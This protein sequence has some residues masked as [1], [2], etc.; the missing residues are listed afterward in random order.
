MITKNQVQWRIAISV[1]DSIGLQARYLTT[2]KEFDTNHELVSIPRVDKE[3]I[4]HVS[5]FNPRWQYKGMRP[6]LNWVY[7][8]VTSNIPQLY[9][10]QN[11]RAS[12]ALS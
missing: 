7:K 10:Y 3:K 6:T 1:D 4:Y 11:Q 2:K 8:D 9:Q 12:V 5:L